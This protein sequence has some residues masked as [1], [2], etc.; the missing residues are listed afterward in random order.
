MIKKEKYKILDDLFYEQEK[1]NQSTDNIRFININVF[2]II[3]EY[4]IDN[5]ILNSLYNIFGNVNS[6]VLMLKAS[7]LNYF[8]LKTII[9]KIKKNISPMWNKKA[10]SIIKDD[11]KK[12]FKLNIN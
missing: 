6:L 9:E 5:E 12:R 1:I 10:T 8:N 4:K 3:D 2:D 11:M 7:K